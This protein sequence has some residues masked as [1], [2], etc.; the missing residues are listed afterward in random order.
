ML[1]LFLL[2]LFQYSSY[3]PSLN[4]TFHIFLFLFLFSCCSCLEVEGQVVPGHPLRHQEQRRKH[5]RSVH[6]LEVHER[7]ADSPTRPENLGNPP[8]LNTPD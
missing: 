5:E 7:H 3:Y 2:L 1:L 4:I 6:A 8:V